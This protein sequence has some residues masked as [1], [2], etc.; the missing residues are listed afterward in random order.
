MNRPSLLHLL[1]IVIFTSISIN[2]YSQSSTE[3]VTVTLRERIADDYYLSGNYDKA[4]SLYGYMVKEIIDNGEESQRHHTKEYFISQIADCHFRMGDRKY[5]IKWYKKL[6]E[7]DMFREETMN[8]YM[9][10]ENPST[11]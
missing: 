6:E 4:L 11:D 3:E 7:T 8:T 1:C 10:A 2:L 5:A 9:T